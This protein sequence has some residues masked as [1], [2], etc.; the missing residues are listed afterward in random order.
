MQSHLKHLHTTLKLLSSNTFFAN[1]KK[2]LFGQQQIGFLGHMITPRGVVVDPDKVS[3]VCEWPIPSNVKE[4]RGFLGLTRYYRRFVRNYGAIAHPLTE[5]TKKDSF[6]WSPEAEKAFNCLKKALIS[7]P[8]LQLP[9][10]LLPFTV[11]CDAS[12]EGIGAILL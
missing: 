7:V 1:A 8:V 5:I 10:F 3:A 4:L 6:R 12:S 9:N 2:C 11:E